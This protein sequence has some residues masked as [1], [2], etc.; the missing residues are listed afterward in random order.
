[1]SNRWVLCAGLLGW[2]II[3][4]VTLIAAVPLGHDESQYV[5]AGSDLLAGRPA[6]WL[7]LSQGTTLIAVPGILAGGSELALRVLPM[8]LGFGFIAAAYF[9]ARTTTTP[10]TAAWLVPVLAASFGIVK[11]NTELLSDMPAAAALLAG[12]ALLVTELVREGGPRRRMVLA[13][14]AF[15]AAM[16]LRYGSA[17]P[18]AIIGV[19]SAIGGWR[20]VTRRPLL[21]AATLGVFVALLTPHMLFAYAKT[22]SPFGIITF[23]TDMIQT[24]SEPGLVT[25]LTS[26]PLR[27]YGIVTAPLLVLGLVSIIWLRDRRLVMLWVMA[28]ASVIGL[29]LTALA[30][31]R[32]I[33]F[34]QVVLLV[35]GV[36][37]VRQF[38]SERKRLVLACGVIVLASWGVTL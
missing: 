4:V 31:S 18:I 21:V 12:A 13:G 11:R 28:I 3:A 7:Y 24:V 16:Y 38:V 36:E 19:V 1:M 5:I 22:G 10:A 17:L 8:L 2:T 32:Y 6:R 15:A 9:L 35:L 29:G 34:S 25:Y 26:P 37:L 27:W 14:V 20:G 23:S 30:Q 33:Y